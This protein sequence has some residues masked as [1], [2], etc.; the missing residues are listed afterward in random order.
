MDMV[1]KL[2]KNGTW[3]LWGGKN[4]I[5]HESLL[6]DLYTTCAQKCALSNDTPLDPVWGKV[7]ELSGIKT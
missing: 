2:S 7:M 4:V 3:K 1:L 5:E 6:F